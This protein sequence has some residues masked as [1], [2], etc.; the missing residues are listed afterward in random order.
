MGIPGAALAGPV[1]SGCPDIAEGALSSEQRYALA[2]AENDLVL[3]RL[4]TGG[5]ST[6][7]LPFARADLIAL[8]PRGATAALYRAAEGTVDVVAGLPFAPVLKRQLR[9]PHGSRELQSLAVSDDGLLVL[10]SSDEPGAAPWAAIE[11][12][13]VTLPVSGSVLAIAV[14]PLR[15]EAAIL[16]ADGVTVARDLAGS[17]RYRFLIDSATLPDARWLAYSLTGDRVVVAGVA[18]K[19]LV[20]DASGGFA[21]ALSCDCSPDGLRRLNGDAVFALSGSARAVR[22][23]DAGGAQP[24]L[25]FVPEIMGVPSGLSHGPV[26]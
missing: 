26:E 12:R 11:D 9:V 5:C 1:L 2:S 8:S 18:G 24:R 20:V 4:D 25:V 13:F 15:G 14:R 21:A 19:I 6:D 7:S 10:G 3:V 16:T 17:P 23:L 22:L